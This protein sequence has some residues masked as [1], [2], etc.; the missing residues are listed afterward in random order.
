MQTPCI[1]ETP[2]RADTGLCVQPTLGQRQA[3]AGPS[4][5]AI[6]SQLPPQPWEGVLQRQGPGARLTQCPELT[7]DVQGDWH[8]E[9]ANLSPLCSAEVPRTGL[10]S[11]PDQSRKES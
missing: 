8:S 10:I 11:N 7:Q 5:M 2:C 1:N 3:E 9:G 6:V 4:A